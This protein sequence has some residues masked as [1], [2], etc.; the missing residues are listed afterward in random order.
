MDTLSLIRVTQGMIS[1]QLITGLVLHLRKEAV[2]L[3]FLSM[4]QEIRVMKE[5]KLQL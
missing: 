5:I 1:V 3:F 4:I 2:E